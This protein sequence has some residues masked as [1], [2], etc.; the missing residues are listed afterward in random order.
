MN[1][2]RSRMPQQQVLMSEGV[3]RYF[4][5]AGRLAIGIPTSFH[6]R[7]RCE[8]LVPDETR[9]PRTVKR[10]GPVAI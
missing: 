4:Y 10:R 3:I 2:C 8:F 1:D 7:K 5:R 6:A 9:V